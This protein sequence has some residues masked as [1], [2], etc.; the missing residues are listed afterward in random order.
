MRDEPLLDTDD[1]SEASESCRETV[2]TVD[3]VEPTEEEREDDRFRSGL[4]NWEAKSLNI[5]SRPLCSCL[6]MSGKWVRSSA[7]EVMSLR[8]ESWP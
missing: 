2:E 1:F 4:S 8:L 7:N 3:R 6:E 5:L